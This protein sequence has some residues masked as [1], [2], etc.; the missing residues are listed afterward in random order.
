[1][2]ASPPA[3]PGRAAAIDGLRALAALSVLGYHAWLYTRERVSAG[4]RESLADELAH[5]LRLGLVLF[6]VLSGYLLFGPWV[7]AVLAGGPAPRTGAYLLR[8]VA[9]IVPAYWVAVA[10]SIALVWGLGD[11]PGV[12]LPPVEDLWLFAV[13]G[14]NFTTP[15]LLK[16]NAPLWTL[17]VEASFY[18][19]LPVLGWLAL[20]L[21]GAGREAQA[22]VPTLFLLLGVAWNWSIAGQ[23]VPPTLT[24]LL[25][26]M[27]PYFAVGMLAAVLGHGRV[28][29]AQGARRLLA[30]GVVLVAVDAW[31]AAVAA[32]SG[33]HDL[34]LH[35]LRDL[36]AACG[37]G[38][39]ILAVTA[40]PAPR[41]L[42]ARPLAIVGLWSYGIYLWH[43]PLLLWMRSHGVLPTSGWAAF[44]LVL[45]PTLA[46]AAASWTLIERP[47]QDCARRA[48]RGRNPARGERRETAQALGRP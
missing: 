41:L 10:G 28:L 19:V 29:G 43:V 35:V 27:A 23:S 15:T 18:V 17:A 33:S 3:E 16:L 48:L 38:A 25:P 9:R 47:A 11:T 14:Q 20:R 36:V 5:E 8:R 31:W 45:L 32:R 44:A 24:K 34:T 13:F 6:F 26:A 39:V 2:R 4:V 46:V 30:A 12:R 1:M 22:I 7:R 21:R 40:G 42:R 37:F